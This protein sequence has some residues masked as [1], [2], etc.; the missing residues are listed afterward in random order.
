M[1]N[2][3]LTIWAL[4]LLFA[5]GL[6]GVGSCMIAD[7]K[8]K[9]TEKREAADKEVA[10][11]RPS[12]YVPFEMNA[13]SECPDLTPFIPIAHIPN[14]MYA[15]DIVIGLCYAMVCQ[16]GQ[17]VVMN[18]VPC[19]LLTTRLDWLRNQVTEEGNKTE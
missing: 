19:S 17:I 2:R 9:E 6:P 13:M 18:E 7:A 10:I 4:V 1:S 15:K 16:K 3:E 11:Q 14:M 8:R 5:A 12:D